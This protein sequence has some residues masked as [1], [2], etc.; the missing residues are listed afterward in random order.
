MSGEAAD[1]DEETVENWH[2]RLKVIPAGFKPKD[3]WNEDETGCF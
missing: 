2:E 1:I 3:I